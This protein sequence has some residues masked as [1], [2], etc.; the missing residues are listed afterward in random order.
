MISELS[1]DSP[2]F[3]LLS[4]HC[5]IGAIAAIVAQSKGYPLGKRIYNLNFPL[6]NTAKSFLYKAFRFK[7][8]TKAF[9]LVKI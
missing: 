4:L 8:I 3:I 9:F 6:L 2:I 5:L 1:F 7:N